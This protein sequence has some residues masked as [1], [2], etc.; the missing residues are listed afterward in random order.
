MSEI[1]DLLFTSEFAYSIIRVTTP[2]LFAA[3]GAVIANTAG[4]ANIALEGLMLIAALVGVIVSA[5]TGSAWLGLIAAVLS[6]VA[7]AGVLAFFTLYY[8]TNVILGGIALNLFASG[9]TVFF[10]YLFAD[11]KGTSAA[12]A[13]KVLPTIHIP[14]LKDIPVLGAIL[15]GHNILTYMAALAVVVIYLMFKKTAFGYRLKAV[16]E[17]PNAAD[18]VGINVMRTKTVALLLSGA[19]AGL[20]GAF[21]SMGYVSWFARD[22]VAGRG[23][24]AIAAEAMGQ[25]STIGTTITSLLFGAADA[26]A[27]ALGTVGIPSELLRI[28]PYVV[29][30]LG[31]LAYALSENRKKKRKSKGA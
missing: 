13:S 6:S 5:F 10:L 23:W 2:I 16:G 18:S 4:I 19:L 29:T 17:N 8:K 15:S 11:D 1:M 26:T 12:L 27:N 14:I 22:M 3:L 24:I 28:L 30:L 31:L 7:F 21:M 25:S 20:G 9:G